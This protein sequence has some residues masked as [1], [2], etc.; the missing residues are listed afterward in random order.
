MINIRYRTLKVQGYLP[1]TH[2]HPQPT[3]SGFPRPLANFSFGD[4][5]SDISESCP[6]PNIACDIN[7]DNKRK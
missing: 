4:V 5:F 7:K 1:P 2:S 3:L 6:L